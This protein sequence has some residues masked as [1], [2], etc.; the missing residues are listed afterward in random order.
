MRTSPDPLTERLK[1]RL[2]S[3]MKSHVD[4]CSSRKGISVSE[5]IRELIRKDMRNKTMVDK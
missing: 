1:L 2:N 3:E 5:Y 4:K